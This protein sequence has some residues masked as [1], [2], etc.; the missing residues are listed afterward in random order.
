MGS[1]RRSSPS[2]CTSPPPGALILDN[3]LANAV[4]DRSGLPHLVTGTG[5]SLPWSPYRYAVY[6]HWM[7]QTARRVGVAP[8]LLELT[9]FRPP[10]ELNDEN[11]AAD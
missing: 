2:S 4:Y 10:G 8:E 1:A 9:L 5:R 11:D 6:L 3:R 7:G